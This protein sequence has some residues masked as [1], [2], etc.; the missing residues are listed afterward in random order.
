MNA[1]VHTPTPVLGN[2][3]GSGITLAF[4]QRTT[5]RVRHVEG[6]SWRSRRAFSRQTGTRWEQAVRRPKRRPRPSRTEA[7]PGCGRRR[8]A[9]RR[10]VEEPVDG[11]RPVGCLHAPRGPWPE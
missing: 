1:P 7:T 4:Q 11:G 8:S 2:L 5:D 6:P 3:L 9:L 10:A